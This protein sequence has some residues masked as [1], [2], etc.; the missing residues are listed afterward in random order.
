P[1]SEITISNP[2]TEKLDGF[3]SLGCHVTTSNI[4]AINSGAPLIFLCVKPW[5]V[6]KV[7]DE[8]YA[9]L[10]A[11]GATLGIVAAGLSV[12]DIRDS[13]PTSTEACIVMPNTGLLVNN[14]TTLVVNISCSVEAL[15]HLREYLLMVGDVMQTTEKSL[16]AATAIAS[17]GIA[18]LMRY[19]RAAQQA[20]VQMGLRASEAQWLAASAMVAAG[21][22]LR[23]PGAHP[24]T[25]IDKVTTP[26]GLTIKGLNAL[27]A[28]G[29]T[30]AVIEAHL[31]SS[32]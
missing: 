25:E 19:V 32:K 23:L 18:Y 7:I 22:L 10:S 24:E 29:F 12:G 8:I 11:S 5:I 14:S 2:S 28:N 1:A 26:G 4:E 13:L 17:C 20:G 31:K 16:P 15:K 3:A 9:D 6:E 21:E 27:D 30:N